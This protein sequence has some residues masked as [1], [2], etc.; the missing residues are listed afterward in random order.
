VEHFKKEIF[1]HE[2]PLIRRRAALW[3][4]GHIGSTEYGFRLI[5]ESKM[6]KDIVRMAE[7]SEILSLRG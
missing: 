1:S 3:A 7:S 2:V 5:K 6:I 4:I